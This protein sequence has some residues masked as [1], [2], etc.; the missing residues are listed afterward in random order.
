LE[1]AR[2]AARASTGPPPA[3]L[4]ISP[5]NNIDGMRISTAIG[6]LAPMRHHLNL[7]VRGGVFVRKV[8]IEDGKA[9]G[10]EAESGGKMFRV[11]A[12]RVVLSAGAIRSPHLL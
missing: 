8:V 3:G 6:H 11:N 7:T 5:S 10:V 2:H 4:G 1:P 12:D 9:V